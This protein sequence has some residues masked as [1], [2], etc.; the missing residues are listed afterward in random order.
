MVTLVNDI[1]VSTLLIMT[2]LNFLSSEIGRM[3]NKHGITLV[4]ELLLT[5]FRVNLGLIGIRILAIDIAVERIVHIRSQRGSCRSF[6]NESLTVTLV[7]PHTYLQQTRFCR[8]ELVVQAI[9]RSTCLTGLVINIGIVRTAHV[10]T[11]VLAIEVFAIDILI[12]IAS[13]HQEKHVIVVFVLLV[14]LIH[15]GNV[16]PSNI[17]DWIY[18]FRK[19]LCVNP[20]GK[21]G[22]T[23]KR[24]NFLHTRFVLIIC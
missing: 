23:N 17:L 4:V 6:N 20:H 19:I 10:V 16:T 18:I 3:L 11:L 12:A 15:P 2:S 7:N 21:K 1:G 5:C 24:N 22:H 8:S 9:A 13:T 14:V